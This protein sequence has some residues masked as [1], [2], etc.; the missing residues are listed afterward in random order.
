MSTYC[1]LGTVLDLR[2]KVVNRMDYTLYSCFHWWVG[3]GC[4][5]VIPTIDVVCLIVDLLCIWTFDIV[6]NLIQIIDMIQS[7]VHSETAPKKLLNKPFIMSH[8]SHCV[9]LVHFKLGFLDQTYLKKN[10]NES[11]RIKYPYGVPVRPLLELLYVSKY[12]VSEDSGTHPIRTAFPLLWV[13]LFRKV[14]RG[15]EWRSEST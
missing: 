12:F 6:H 2:D 14:S 11:Y 5:L 1:R 10:L 13:S 4:S 8:E 3:K 7:W 15:T 9:P